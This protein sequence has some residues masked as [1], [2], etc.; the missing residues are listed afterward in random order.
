[1]SA[2]YGTVIGSA[3]TNATRRG[4]HDIKV[5]A[6]SWNGSVITRLYYNEGTL[7]VDIQI[8]E[9]SATSGY[10]AFCGTLAE[11]KRRLQDRK[12]N[13]YVG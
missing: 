7:M 2:F 10:T 8:S 4:H 3:D 6:Q 11:L 9:D 13:E 1:M 5:A 12:E